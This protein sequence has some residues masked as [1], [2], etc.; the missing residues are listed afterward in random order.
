MAV[1]ASL[2]VNLT[3]T[4]GQFTST[5]TKATKTMQIVGAT[6]TGIG[7]AVKG[8]V[9][10]AAAK[11]AFNFITH[12]VGDIHD[13]A[14][15][16]EKAGFSLSKMDRVK[17][18][19][20]QVAAEKISGAFDNMK[21]QLVSGLTPAIQFVAE[22]MTSFTNQS[23]NGFS[24]M[25]IA[26]RA[27][28]AVV[29]LIG[30]SWQTSAKL[31]AQAMVPVAEATAGVAAMI[32]ETSMKFMDIAGASKYA[33]IAERAGRLAES[34]KGIDASLKWD[35][36][37]SWPEFKATATGIQMEAKKIKEIMAPKAI[38]AGSQESALFD[39]K[40]RETAMRAKQDPRQQAAEKQVALLGKIDRGIARLIQIQGETTVVNA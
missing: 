39:F 14:E 24:L 30:K 13:L 17:L 21:L 25:E 2:N 7:R 32:A 23:I 33:K 29:I 20:A 15:G 19:S 18:G 22:A 27:A 1:A 3:A 36:I 4:S 9:V 31:M 6:A 35:E 38:S 5:M 37:L 8:L 12:A 26:G 34:L 10:A 40:R 28:G 16:A 11:K